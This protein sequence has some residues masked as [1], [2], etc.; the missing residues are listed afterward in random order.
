MEDVFSLIQALI[1]E[2]NEA[3]VIRLN[4]LTVLDKIEGRIGRKLL[5][6]RIGVTERTL[7]TVI[8]H[9]RE[10]GLV[11]ITQQ[12]ITLTNFGHQAR[13]QLQQVLNHS[14]TEAFIEMEVQLRK[15]LGIDHCRLVPGDGDIDLYVYKLLGRA[16]Q[17][18]LMKH[19][20]RQDSVVAVTGGSTLAR[21]G[22]EFN[23][24]LS[25]EHDITFVPTR[26]GFG[27]AF[28]IQSNTIGGIMAQ[29]TQSR[30]VPFF[31]PDN[32]SKEGSR[33]LLKDPTI[34][35]A[36][37]LSKRADCL[38]LSVG[39]AEVIAERRDL[40]QDQKE[41]IRQGESVGEAFG[42]FFD[43]D[44]KEVFKYSRLGM[45]LEDIHQIPLMITV[46]AGGS[47]AEAIKAFYKFAP[48]NSWLVCDEGIAKRIINRK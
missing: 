8:D 35:R 33:V 12:G 18:I 39:S 2:I 38:I 46:V 5:A 45:Q 41:I 48:K 20:P 4:I 13:I 30:Y 27:G 44:G 6:E 9:M 31:V 37:E 3:L 11:D 43:K 25:Q 42:V 28:D 22:K 21:I 15:I 47:K 34:N 16:V 40:N 7:R 10:Q 17:D 1:P 26:G 14:R 23:P 29:Q 36:V 32:I 24:D 19:L